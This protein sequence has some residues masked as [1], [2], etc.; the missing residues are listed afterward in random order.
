MA[1]YKNQ[2][3]AEMNLIEELSEVIQV[4]TKKVRFGGDWHEV[5]PGHSKTRFESL[6]SEMAD[7]MLA[8]NR[9]L[10]EVLEDLK[11]ESDLNS[12]ENQT[13]EG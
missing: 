2:G 6:T 4:V 1:Q 11:N 10:R 9:V 13:Y 12:L 7:V 3:D 5:P 8:Y